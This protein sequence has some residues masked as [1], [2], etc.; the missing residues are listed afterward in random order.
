MA[1]VFLSYAKEDRH[2][3]Q[4]VAAA[5][6]GSGW[7][8]WWDADLVPGVRY[9]EEIAAQLSSA[10]CV[11]ALWSAESVKSDYVRD[12]AEEGKSR[13]VLVQALIEDVQAPHGFRQ[14]QWADLTGWDGWNEHPGLD[15]LRRGVTRHV[16]P[17]TSGHVV[18]D[19]SVPHG[20]QGPTV[21]L[22]DAR[23]PLRF[24]PA[25]RKTVLALAVLAFVAIAVLNVWWRNQSAEDRLQST[26]PQLGDEV[27]VFIGNSV[28]RLVLGADEVILQQ[29]EAWRRLIPNVPRIRRVVNEEEANVRVNTYGGD[30]S[31]QFDPPAP[32]SKGPSNILIRE[33]MTWTDK[34]FLAASARMWGKILGL[35]ETDT[36][37]QLMTKGVMPH[38]LP[39]APQSEDIA[40]ARAIWGTEPKK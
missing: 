11:V 23:K 2:R 31:V 12:E 36:P 40:R 8:V 16:Q 3:A 34:S 33:Y 37:G 17:S 14:M 35:Q 20:I 39:A 7:S 21:R 27:R 10:R 30:E 1:D 4:Q 22:A 19:D 5:L 32:G 25:N 24:V 28:A 29:G 38:D 18:R 6:T 15:G 9:R 13:G 26:R